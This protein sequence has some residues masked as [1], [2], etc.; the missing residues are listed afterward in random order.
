[1]TGQPHYWVA[2]GAGCKLIRS[3]GAWEGILVYDKVGYLHSVVQLLGLISVWWVHEGHDE[4]LK[5]ATQL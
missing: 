3:G 1:M 4:S 5:F 2:V